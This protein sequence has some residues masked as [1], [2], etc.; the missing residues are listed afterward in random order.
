MKVY[1]VSPKKPNSAVRKIARVRFLGYKKKN[2]SALVGIPGQGF[3]LKAFCT[4]LVRGG[5]VQDVPGI[6]YK[7]IRGKFD[8]DWKE[9]IRRLNRRSKYSIP[10]APERFYDLFRLEAE[11]RAKAKDGR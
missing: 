11:S 3:E 6:N 1:R 2:V 5:R 9:D 10:H 7:M 8:L 4:V